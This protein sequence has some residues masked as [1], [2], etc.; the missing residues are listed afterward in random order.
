MTTTTKRI[1]L[2]LPAFLLVAVAAVLTVSSISGTSLAS[3]Q[4]LPRRADIQSVTPDAI[5]PATTARDWVEV[6]GTRTRG[7]WR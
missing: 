3:V 1:L 5:S 6:D 7:G 2:A 4:E